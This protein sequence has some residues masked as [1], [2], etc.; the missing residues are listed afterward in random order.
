MAVT[1]DDVRGTNSLGFQQYDDPFIQDKLDDA[2]TEAST[3]YTGRVSN[4]PTIDG[5]RDI[6]VKNLA[7]HK[8]ELASGGST[9]SESAT[10]GNVSYVT[11]N[12]SDPNTYLSLTQY[13][14][15]C[16]AHLRDETSIGLVTTR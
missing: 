7:A 6:F 13:G 3:I 15:T 9:E 2:E 4:M 14:E 11:S 5:D 16:K 12:P 8:V 10:G 1:V